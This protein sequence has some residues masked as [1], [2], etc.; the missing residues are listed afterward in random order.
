MLH[1]AGP[2]SPWKRPTKHDLPHPTVQDD[3]TLRLFSVGR[4]LEHLGLE[5]EQGQEV[6]LSDEHRARKAGGHLEH[7]SAAQQRSLKHE[8]D[9]DEKGAGQL[10]RADV[11]LSFIRHLPGEGVTDDKIK[12]RTYGELG[13]PDRKPIDVEGG[14]AALKEHLRQPPALIGRL[15]GKQ[16]PHRAVECP[17]PV[18]LDAGVDHHAQQDEEGH[19]ER[20]QRELKLVEAGAL[21]RGV[22]HIGQAYQLSLIHI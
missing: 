11:V 21:G 19:I 7:L 10:A 14:A 12:D 6:E 4:L 15:G 16:A 3:I 9:S 17:L 1:C 18:D 5:V 22:E 13:Q 8:E 2:D 20:Q